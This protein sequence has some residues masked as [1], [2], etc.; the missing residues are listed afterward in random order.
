MA[1]YQAQLHVMTNNLTKYKHILWYGFRR[2]A[3]TRS[4]YA[5]QCIKYSRSHNTY[6]LC[7]ITMGS[8]QVQLHVMTNTFCQTVSEV[9]RSQRTETI[10]MLFRRWQNSLPSFAPRYVWKCFMYYINKWA[11]IILVSCVNHITTRCYTYGLHNWFI[12]I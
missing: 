6:T 4:Y 12:M 10:T 1:P 8:K 7:R 11:C 2:V 9:L 5:T 3:C